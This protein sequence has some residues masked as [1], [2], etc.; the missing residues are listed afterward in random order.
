MVS[1]SSTSEKD[2]LVLWA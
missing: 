2:N 1:E